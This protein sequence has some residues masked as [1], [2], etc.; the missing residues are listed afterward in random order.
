MFQIRER[1]SSQWLSAKRHLMLVL[2]FV[3]M[4][5]AVFIVDWLLPDDW[6]HLGAWGIRPRE[7]SGV[8]S[9][10]VAPF[11][12]VDFWHLLANTIPLLVLG[13]ILVLSGRALFV[14]VCV[15]T[16]LTSG[17][18][19]WVFGQGGVIHEGASGVLFGMLGF[20]LARGWFARRLVWALTSLIV[21]LFYLGEVLSLLRTSNPQISWSSHFWGFA[22][23]IALAWW[24]Y[25]RGTVLLVPA[26][27]SSRSTTPAPAKPSDT[28]RR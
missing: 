16:G 17:A 19:A 20:L 26:A 7:V 2:V 25:G 5:W 4:L 10:A 23:G 18:G 9:I 6:L 24:M 8:F 14:R 21:G 27:T 15:V 1:L 28:A 22:G 13:W 3:G 11:L 12:H